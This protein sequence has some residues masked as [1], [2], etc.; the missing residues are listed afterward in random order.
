MFSTHRIQDVD[1]LVGKL[2]KLAHSPVTINQRTTFRIETVLWNFTLISAGSWIQGSPS[3][4]IGA[5]PN[6]RM[7]TVEA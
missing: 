3:L 6:S 4:C 5:R 1:V 2:R 7:V